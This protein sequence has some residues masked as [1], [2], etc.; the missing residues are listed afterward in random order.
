MDEQKLAEAVAKAEADWRQ[1]WMTDEWMGW[2]TSLDH[3]FCSQYADG[4]EDFEIKQA[5][6]G[7]MKCHSMH[8]PDCGKSCGGQGHFSCPERKAKKWARNFVTTDND[9]NA[10]G[11]LVEFKMIEDENGD[12]FW[13]YGH[14]DRE[15][16]I[17]EINRWL[18]HCGV[19]SF[20]QI[21]AAEHKVDHLWAKY[22]DDN[23]E[24]FKLVKDTGP[25]ST[26]LCVDAFPVTRLML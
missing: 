9:S 24:R 3:A 11:K 21:A 2:W 23:E 6:P 12:V 7:Y 14:V 18:V 16:F 5:M 19:G 22:N 4:P 20:D 17:A 15:E 25:M 1:P 13:A 10:P 8:C 26:F